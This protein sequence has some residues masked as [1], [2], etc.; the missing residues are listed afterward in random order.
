MLSA[1]R[2]DSMK[3]R[4]ADGVSQT[5]MVDGNVG[6]R[7]R[8]VARILAGSIVEVRV[9]RLANVGDV[10]ALHAQVVAAIRRAGPRPVICADH[11]LASPLSREV[12]DA[13]SRV[14]R[15]NNASGVRGGLLLDPSNVM[16][17]LQIERVVRCAGNP[18]RRLFVDIDLLRDWIGGPLSESER[19]ALDGLFADRA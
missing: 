15:Q 12:A 4:G 13:W 14:M 7:A 6:S 5:L 18:G 11:R 9:R 1:P 17:N 16:Y 10:A 8:S 2:R 3:P 19:K